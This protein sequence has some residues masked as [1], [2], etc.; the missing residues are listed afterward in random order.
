MDII[1]SK[2]NVLT[3]LYCELRNTDGAI[4]VLIF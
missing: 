1:A 3:G 4:G 2:K